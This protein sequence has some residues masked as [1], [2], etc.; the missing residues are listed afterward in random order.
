MKWY[1]LSGSSVRFTVLP[2]WVLQL[3][4]NGTATLGVWTN[5]KSVFTMPAGQA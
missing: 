4:H 3:T 1:P 5:G 2:G